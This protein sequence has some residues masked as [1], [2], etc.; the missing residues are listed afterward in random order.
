MYIKDAL[1]AK[2]SFIADNSIINERLAITKQKGNS[3]TQQG[4]SSLNSKSYSV[5]LSSEAKMMFAVQTGKDGHLIVSSEEDKEKLLYML[6]NNED[7]I[8]NQDIKKFCEEN[9]IDMS[10]PIENL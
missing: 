6:G 4:N 10:Q 1:H 2:D 9:G 8:V 5:F 3:G 7:K